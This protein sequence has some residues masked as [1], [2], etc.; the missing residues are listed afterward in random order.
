VEA[1]RPRLPLRVAVVF[2]AA[3]LIWIAV[4]TALAPLGDPHGNRLGHAARALVTVALAVPAVV[5][6]R[7]YLDRRPWRGL[8]LVAPRRALAGATFWL[9]AAALGTAVALALGWAEV[10]SGPWA[11]RTLLLALYL[12]VLV[13]LFEALP[14]ELVFRGYLY[15]NLADRFPR[16]LAVVGQAVLFTAFGL[17]IGAAGSLERIILFFTFSLTLGALRVVTGSLWAPIGF[18]LAFQYVTQ[19]TGA[20]IRDGALRIEGFPDLEFV[21]FWL[22]PIVVGGLVL[23]VVGARR[24]LWR[25]SEPDR[26]G[27][28][29]VGVWTQP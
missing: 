24:G 12:P 2:A 8:G 21:A 29:G 25:A 18:H 28:S 7:R 22:L 14:E 16:W 27:Q 3:C 4:Y 26:S 19:F 10:T 1:S 15:R 6:A 5:L 11:P 13:F 17:V 20:A 23:A 9:A